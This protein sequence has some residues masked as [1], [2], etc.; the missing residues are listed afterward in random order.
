M[1]I[2]DYFSRAR[3][4][5]GLRVA[6][7]LGDVVRGHK[8]GVGAAIERA[9]GIAASSAPGPDVPALGLEVKTLPVE[10]GRVLQSTWVCSASPD[11]LARETWVR[12]RARQKLA[13]VLWVPVE[14]GS[15]PP[16]ERRVGTAFLW[17]PNDVEEG[18]LRD[19]WEDLADIVANGHGFAVTAR[20][21]RAL[22]LRPKAA[23]ASVRR[24]STT[25]DGEEYEAAP[26]GF[27]LRRSFTQ[28]LVDARFGR[29][30]GYGAPVPIR[31]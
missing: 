6:G 30:P 26:Q 12:S 21:G 11:A 3:A 8:G 24:Q 14:G 19:D 16:T 10:N 20:R 4:L 5:A 29:P 18:V 2:E 23:D 1:D 22:Q 9:L 27:Y 15:V 17:Q 28:A 7:L 31:S 25:V 13:C